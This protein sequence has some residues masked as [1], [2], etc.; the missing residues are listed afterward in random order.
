MAVLTLYVDGGVRSTVARQHLQKLGV[1]FNEIN[2]TADNNAVLFLESKNRP[3][4]K[5]PMPQ[6]YVGETL[7]WSEGYKDVVEL[8][9][10]QINERISELN[11]S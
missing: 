3:S 9:A 11:A 7:A 10:E 2:V 1:T 8:T 5:H 4:K 6:Y